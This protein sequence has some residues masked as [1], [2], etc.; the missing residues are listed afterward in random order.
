MQVRSRQG[1]PGWTY[2]R[3]GTASVV[4]AV[5]KHRW[6]RMLRRVEAY[7]PSQARPSHVTTRR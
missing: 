3:A 4:Y 5:R 2:E 7:A 1:S 6:V